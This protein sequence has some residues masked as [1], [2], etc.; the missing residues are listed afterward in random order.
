M[1]TARWRYIMGTAKIGLDTNGTAYRTG[2]AGKTGRARIG[3]RW[4]VLAAKT[5]IWLRPQ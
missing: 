5:Y 2:S 1:K 3:L 4:Y